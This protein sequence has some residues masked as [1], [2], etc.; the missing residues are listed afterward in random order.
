MKKNSLRSKLSLLLVAVFMV[1]NSPVPATAAA[2]SENGQDKIR[3][4]LNGKY[5]SSDAVPIIENS[6]TMVP[7][8]V[9]SEE[10][11]A[12]VS[13]NNKDSS[14]MVKTSENKQI[15][16]SIGNK[17]AAISSRTGSNAAQM[18]VAPF[19]KD[20]KTMVPLRFIAEE[21][22]LGV[23]WDNKERIVSLTKSSSDNKAAA[24]AELDDYIIAANS[25]KE[26][27]ISFYTNTA[28]KK[29][30]VTVLTKDDPVFKGESKVKDD[31]LSEYRLELLFSD[32]KASAALQD[33]LGLQTVQLS[34]NNLLQSIRLA[35]PP[36][37]SA[38]VI[39]LGCKSLPR[40]DLLVNDN[41]FFL[42][43]V[44]ENIQDGLKV[45]SKNIASNSEAAQVKLSIPQIDGLQDKAVQNSINERFEKKALQFKEETFEG[46]DEYVKDAKKE[47][48]P[49]RTYEALTNYRVTYSKDD[50]LSLYADYYSYTGGAHGFTDR[51]HSNIDLNTGKE[52]QLKDLFKAGVDY[53]GII[54]NE[55][56]RQMQLDPEKYFSESL[57]EWQGIS[58]DQ[59]YYIEDGSLI[60]YFP[61]YEIAP[62]AS[63]IPEF[64]I[65]VSALG[66]NL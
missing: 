16:L 32:V 51:V 27:D 34:E 38:M 52:L 40:A 29:P 7:V 22:G 57:T 19:L 50:L 48:W 58:E 8:R 25:S 5:L 64:K 2:I 9:I 4:S 30:Q 11:G 6:T 53:K 63:G 26:A 43:L 28:V 56:K 60:V 54:N 47:G 42:N 12:E 31:S 3:I 23:N 20:G 49:I 45:S 41:G 66:L 37:D 15:Q 62:Y 61:L 35:Y 55:I 33:K 65:P 24:K 13:W 44:N 1:M 46:L 10:L 14:V 59:P 17:Q 21:L 36:D 18:G 39:Y